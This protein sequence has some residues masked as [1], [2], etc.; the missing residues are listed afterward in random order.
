MKRTVAGM[1]HRWI[2]VPAIPAYK[3]E[4]GNGNVGVPISIL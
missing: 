2:L 1:D 3:N 4:F